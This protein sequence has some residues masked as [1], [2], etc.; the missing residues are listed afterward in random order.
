MKKP[1]VLLIFFALWFPV[2][3]WAHTGLEKAVPGEGETVKEDVRNIELIFNTNIESTSTFDVRDQTGKTIK[4]SDIRVK[5]KTLSG[6]LN[7]PLPPGEYTV[8]WRIIGADGHPVKGSYSFRV[9]AEV[10][11]KPTEKSASEKTTQEAPR[12]TEK[13]SDASSNP[14]GTPWVAGV[15]LALLIG[16][17]AGF[18]WM[19]RKR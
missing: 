10:K 16:A 3:V 17:V 1:L 5:G 19:W 12:D 4:P 2:T 9:N 13:K 8:H 14:A 7:E 15:L 18:F 11:E 6:S